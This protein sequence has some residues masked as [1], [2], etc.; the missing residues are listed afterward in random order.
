MNE[1]LGFTFQFIALVIN[2][3]IY[4]EVTLLSP[5]ILMFKMVSNVLLLVVQW[6][7]L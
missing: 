1:V 5:V 6:L 7:K 4:F 3:V 2:V